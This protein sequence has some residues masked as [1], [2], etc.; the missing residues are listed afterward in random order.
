MEIQNLRNIPQYFEGKGEVKGFAFTQIKKCENAYLF[1]VKTP[2]NT[3]H[4]EVFKHKINKQY[5]NVSY[6][7]SKS[8]GV[9]AWCCNTL[10][11]AE[12]RYSELESKVKEAA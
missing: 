1:Q 12:R 8:F 7:K 2:F 5:G 10:E 3:T 11:Q 6:P 9:W 4:Y